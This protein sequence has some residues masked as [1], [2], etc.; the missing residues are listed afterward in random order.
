MLKISN[1]GWSKKAANRVGAMACIVMYGACLPANAQAP[2]ATAPAAKSATAPV[3][4]TAKRSGG[5]AVQPA[6]PLFIVHLTTGPG[7]TKDQSVDAQAGFSEHSKNLLRL[8]NDGL[9]LVGARYKD[10]VA[11]K[12][13]LIV[14]AAN[15]AAVAAE[16]ANDPMV[17]D[18]KFV[19]DIAEFK[20][21]YDGFVAMPDR[22]AATTDSPLSALNWLAGCWFGRNG[23]TE[24][25]EQWMREAGG[26]MLGTGHTT[27]NGKMLSFEAMRIELD[28]NGTPVFVAKPSD[29]EE[30]SF[31]SVKY[32]AEGIV[33][34]NPTHDFPQRIKYLLKADGTLDARIEGMLKGREARIEFPMR[35]ASCE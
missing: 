19:L 33:F 8:R 23:R 3:A 9:I 31:K 6:T 20:P 25:R 7:W 15:K 5:E 14:R 27:A 10:S 1:A 32:D 18:K 35:R 28:A 16:F 26:V 13:M 2:A 34:E 29:Q 17:K 4:I 21:F 12:G 22:T 11:D 30:A 24:F